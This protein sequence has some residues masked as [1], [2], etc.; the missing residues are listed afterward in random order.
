MIKKPKIKMPVDAVVAVTYKCN[1]RCIMC[2]IW[3][4]KDYPE[5]LPEAFLRLPDTLKDVNISGGEAFL[6]QDLPEIIRN[7][8][9][10]CPKAN[11]NISTNG[12]LVEQIKKTLPQ[13]KEIYP[14]IAVSVSIDGVGK[15]HEEVRR[16]PNA[17]E[18]V[19]ETLNYCRGLLGSKKV[20]MAFT[21]NDLNYQQLQKAY[22]WSQK[23]GVQ[24]TM[25]VAH[26][27]DLYFSKKQTNEKFQ[28]KEV[29]DQFEFIIKKLLRSLS[30]KDW[31]R[32]YFV[33]GLYKY[34]Q[35]K[36]RP[37]EQFAGQ[38][39][40]YLDPKGDVYPSVVDNIIMGNLFDYRDFKTLWYSPQAQKARDD[41]KGFEDNY[42][43]VCTART[44][45]KRN[46]LKVANWIFKKKLKWLK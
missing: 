31:V 5:L 13:I 19:V 38:D 34:S 32:A 18:K 23:I 35:G 7:V 3:Q 41:L 39:F 16:I 17:W 10:A 37:L 12:F 25:A 26:S 15:M 27:S 43:M 4:I 36:R 45:I 20:K 24:F 46:P 14:E 44:A 2:N 11:I 6:R 22:E 1:S 33:D 9:R 30:P 28:S 42:W 29:S 40:F 8:K 21:L